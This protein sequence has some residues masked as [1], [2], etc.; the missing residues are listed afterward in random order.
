MSILNRY[1][2]YLKEQ[3]RITR[4][5][6]LIRAVTQI[7]DS[8][9]L[10][11]TDPLLWKI[12]LSE[13]QDTT[14]GRDIAKDYLYEKGFILPLYDGYSNSFEYIRRQVI[15]IVKRNRTKTTRVCY[16]YILYIYNL[17]G[18]L[19]PLQFDITSGAL[20]SGMDSLVPVPGDSGHS[21]S[22]ISTLVSD[23]EFTEI[24]FYDSFGNPQPPV[25]VESIPTLE[26][27]LD[28]KPYLPVPL[29][30]ISGNPPLVSDAEVLDLTDPD[31]DDETT[32]LPPP[33]TGDQGTA[34]FT[35][36]FLLRFRFL[37]LEILDY[38]MTSNTSRSFCDTVFQSC[39]S[40][41]SPIFEPFFTF[42]LN[43]NNT[44]REVE[45]FTPDLSESSFVRSKMF[46]I[47][48]ETALYVQVGDGIFIDP[49]DSEL[50]G[51]QNEIDTFIIGDK[52]NVITFEPT[53]LDIEYQIL[54]EEPFLYEYSEIAIW[55]GDPTDIA[56]SV[57]CYVSFPKVQLFEKLLHGVYFRFIVSDPPV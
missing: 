50:I 7:L 56:S 17:I 51:V 53:L 29:E 55:D 22:G 5:A 39:K 21:S 20:V 26:E 23:S 12:K 18:E 14:L 8:F 47:N 34:V 37:D 9:K 54:P 52:F 11:F 49:D 24:S 44:T 31:F 6:G 28:W 13:I 57:L 36:F 16:N 43:N 10:E 38:F 4:W 30:S 40:V 32:E 15:T 45:F 33:L 2:R 25:S 46:S 19:V 48:L 42:R 35:N 1:L 41:E 3:L 27:W